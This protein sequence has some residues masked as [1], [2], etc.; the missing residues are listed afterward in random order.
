MDMLGYKIPD[1]VLGVMID[2]VPTVL[3]VTKPSAS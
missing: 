1:L 3:G 2:D